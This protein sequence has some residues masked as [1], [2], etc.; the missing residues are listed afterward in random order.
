MNK[1]IAF[2]QVGDYAY[3]ITYLLKHIVRAETLYIP[4]ISSE[5]IELG[6]RYSP[7]FV[8]TPFKYTLGTFIECLELGANVLIQL[9][10]G[11]RYGYYHELQKEILKNLNYHFTYINL[12]TEGKTDIKK[13]IKQFKKID[14]K[15]S[16]LKGLYYLFIT[17][18]MV[19]Y[20]DEIDEYIRYNIGFE[21][22]KNSFLNL[23]KEMLNSFSKTK[24]YFSLKRKY[25]YY[26]NKFKNIKLKNE[27]RFQV[28]I[29][30]ELYTVMEP[31]SNSNS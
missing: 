13:I 20:M 1:I 28:G 7:D 18:N 11:C 4:H 24:G 22:E 17:K 2:P 12:V 5:T 10:G 21:Q 9:G 25:R 8:C 15:F 14:P 30:G 16:V 19:K 27:P 26:K 3:P 6:S 29:I 23:K 31:S